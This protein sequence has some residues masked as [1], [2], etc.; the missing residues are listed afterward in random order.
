MRSSLPLGANDLRVADGLRTS[1]PTCSGVESN[2]PLE[3]APV[4][5]IGLAAADDV[6][7][8]GRAIQS[9]LRIHNR[10]HLELIAARSMAGIMAAVLV[11]PFSTLAIGVLGGG[12]LGFH[13]PVAGGFLVLSGAVACCG[14]QAVRQVVSKIVPLDASDAQQLVR[15]YECSPPFQR[16]FIGEMARSAL[17][18]LH[19]RGIRT[20]DGERSLSRISTQAVSAGVDPDAAKLH[21]ATNDLLTFTRRYGDNPSRAMWSALSRALEAVPHGETDAMRKIVFGILEGARGAC[22]FRHS[23]SDAARLE[24]LREGKNLDLAYV[25][26][27]CNSK[28]RSVLSERDVDHLQHALEALPSDEFRAAKAFVLATFP[29]GH[30]AFGKILQMRTDAF[31]ELL[32]G[33][34][35]QRALEFTV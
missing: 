5:T 9:K 24:A 27:F 10:E 23:P 31:Y 25:I 15:A 12:L 32:S 14:A 7:T 21:A 28:A 4:A 22:A 35:T 30:N 33:G 29:P 3:R 17:N 20:G 2:A 34:G 26:A 1:S 16:A 18:G 13:V 8:A 19:R 11:A 6:L